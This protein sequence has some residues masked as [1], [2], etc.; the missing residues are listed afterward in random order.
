MSKLSQLLLLA[1][2]FILQ[3]VYSFGIDRNVNIRKIN[4]PVSLIYL[5]EPLFADFKDSKKV[6]TTAKVNL[7]TVLNS[8]TLEEWLLY[9]SKQP[10]ILAK[11]EKT[12]IEKKLRELCVNF[13]QISQ[14]VNANPSYISK[15]IMETMG[16]ELIK[17][18]NDIPRFVSIFPN[19]QLLDI[20]I[21]SK[22]KSFTKDEKI[23]VIVAVPKSQSIIPLKRE[24]IYNAKTLDDC[25]EVAKI[26]LDCREE[27]ADKCINQL[28][29]SSDHRRFLNLFSSTKYG[30]E[31]TAKYNEMTSKR[32]ENLGENINTEYPDFGPVISPDGSTIYFTRNNTPEGYGGEDIYVS[33]LDAHGEWTN[34]KNVRTPL[35]NSEHNGVY[36]VSQDG[37]ELFLHNDYESR[38]NDPSITQFEGDGWSFP[39]TQ[40]I[41]N[42]K[43]RGGY[44]NGSLSID[45]KYLVMSV[46]RD[47]SYGGSF[48]FWKTGGNDIYVIA[49]DSIGNWIEPKNLGPIINTDE[50]EGSVFLAADGQTIYFSSAGHGGYG[51]QDMFMSRRLDDTWTNWT[52]PLNLG[53]SINSYRVDDFYVIP[54]KG[55]FIYFSSDR[56]GFGKD[57]IFRIGLPI[58][59][60]PKPVAVIKGSIINKKS[61]K[62][63]FAKVIYE[64]LESGIQLGSVNTNP[65]TGEY[66][67]I[68]VSGK[69]YGITPTMITEIRTEIIS[70]TFI[71]NTIITPKGGVALG[72]FGDK[73]EAIVSTQK[74]NVV[75]KS[76]VVSSKENSGSLDDNY[77]NAEM[78]KNGSSAS[79]LK[80]RSKEYDAISET[81]ENTKTK[82]FSE[83]Q[84]I[85]LT[86]LK[87]YIVI[88]QKLVVVPIE[89]GQTINLNN[90]FFETASWILKKESFLELNRVAKVLME[91]PAIKIEIGGHTDDKGS[92]ET[93]MAL[94]EKRAFEVYSYLTTHS[95]SKDRLVYV[96]YGETKPKVPNTTESNKAANRRVELKIQ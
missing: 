93:N 39:V 88:E 77:S 58:E 68:L 33:K 65:T 1:S 22:A 42:L 20:Y 35:N 80:S 74:D 64:D 61:N 85:D 10:N 79:E 59:M 12:K 24:L 6:D 41:P 3:S 45:G 72:D 90:L 92:D 47:D 37:L 4:V 34:A 30:V 75:G 94:S 76:S 89:T 38:G 18:V 67:I 52:K 32:A 27:L 11:V 25:I 48:L 15:S 91:N 69:K 96:G 62:P 13:T 9:T 23:L 63:V 44:H 53:S 71:E 87:E 55:D 7:Q 29:T 86:D 83:S 78:K 51:A 8:G 70:E 84:Y 40:Q 31:V 14:L 81:G 19:S 54:A 17:N 82:L 95:I 36:S 73:A 16:I 5:N 66:Q 43:A 56:D 50:E 60:R 21:E 49:K 28:E 2:S 57:D 26:C 46:K